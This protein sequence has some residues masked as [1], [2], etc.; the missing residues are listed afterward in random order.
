M[1][2]FRLAVVAVILLSISQC[3]SPPPAGFGYVEEEVPNILV[4]ARYA[5]NQNFTGRPVPG[6][7]SGKLML[8]HQALVRLRVVQR[9]LARRDLG[10]KIF[11][12]YRPQQ[13]VDYFVQWSADPAD[14]IAKSIYYPH[15]LK[16]ELIPN[17]YIA[18]KSGHTRGSTIDLTLV[19]IKSGEE[20]DMGTP[21]DYFGPESHGDFEGIT[22][23][24]RQNRELLNQVMTKHGFKPLAEEWWH[25]TL[26]NEPFP[27]TYF[28][29][30][31]D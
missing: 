5:S 9:D 4:E 11:D 26:V 15:V 29:F 19:H 30:P 18:A 22:T 1:R 10:L 27:D 16:R 3:K 25:F 31:V 7:L 8:T 14:T 23:E 20:L 12:A 24:Q 17:G 28:N 13:A 2:L 6:Y 21:W